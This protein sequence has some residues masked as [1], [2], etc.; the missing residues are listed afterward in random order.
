MKTY[1][2]IG[3]S[4]DLDSI[5]DAISLLS[6]NDYIGGA[7]SVMS[8]TSV[9]VFF[10]DHSY[11]TRMTI[12]QAD[13]PI[14]DHISAPDSEGEPVAYYGHCPHNTKNNEDRFH[15]K[16]DDLGNSFKKDSLRKNNKSSKKESK[17]KKKSLTKE[18]NVNEE[19]GLI[20]D[21]QKNESG[22][23]QEGKGLVSTSL[24]VIL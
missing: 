21:D 5:G 15:D 6:D 7:E 19:K 22:A 18:K 1:W 12:S 11:N 10:G 16:W 13:L 17:K 4:E 2:L 3:R 9:D 20:E 8:R 23:K 24:C 14:H